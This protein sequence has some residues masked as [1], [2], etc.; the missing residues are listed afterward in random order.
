MRSVNAAA[1][2]A[3]THPFFESVSKLGLLRDSPGPHQERCG[4]QVDRRF[5]GAV[6]LHVVLIHR[7][8]RWI[9]CARIAVEL[10]EGIFSVGRTQIHAIEGAG[11]GGIGWSFGSCAPKNRRAS[12]SPIERASD[13]GN[14]MLD[15]IRKSRSVTNDERGTPRVGAKDVGQPS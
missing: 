11:G 14:L 15:A 8:L 4:G 9:E 13:V 12:G 5:G 7:F 3:L 2:F 6:G 10:L 1:A